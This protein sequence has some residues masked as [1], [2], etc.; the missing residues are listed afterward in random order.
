MPSKTIVAIICITIILVSCIFKD[1]DGALVGV[2]CTVI[3]GLGGWAAHKAKT[4]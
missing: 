2:G 4:P 3:A 1:I